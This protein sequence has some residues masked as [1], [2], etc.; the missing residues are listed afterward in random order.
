METGKRPLVSR[1]LRGWGVSVLDSFWGL[2]IAF[3]AILE[4]C[5]ESFA[6][7]NSGIVHSPQR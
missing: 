1:M 6:L 2:H 4:G 3:G 5:P 7:E